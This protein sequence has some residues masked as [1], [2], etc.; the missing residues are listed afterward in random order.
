ML[1]LCLFA[2]M[3]SLPANAQ[4]R[5]KVKRAADEKVYLDHADELRYDEFLRR[6]V[7]IVKGK[8]RFRYDGTVLTCDSAYFNQE[9]NSFEAF[10]HVNIVN[11]SRASSMRCEHARYNGNAQLIE[12]RKGVVLHY[13]GRTLY[14]DS[15]N[16][17]RLTESGNYWDGGRIVMRGMQITS[18]RGEYFNQENKANAY[19]NVVV[20]SPKYIIHTNTLYYDTK[21][22]E[23][24]VVGPST[25]KTQGN[26]IKT[27]E[28]YYYPASDRMRL[29][30]P[31]TI[32]SKER[33]IVGDNLQ[34]NSK[35]GESEGTGHVKVFDKVN[36]RHISGDYLR[37]NSNKRTGRGEGHVHYIDRKN[38]NSLTA[39]Y[40]DY[41]DEKA[42]AYG[43]ALAK[44]FSQKD[45]LFV[46][47]DTLRMF[48]FNLNTDS[49]YRK[50]Y[51][52]HNVRAYRTDVQGVCGHFVYN[53][54]D[55]C[56]RMYNDPI[57]W[58][59]N[60]QILGDSI[61]TYLNDT[62]IRESH[63]MGNALSIELMPDSIHYNQISS[64]EMRSYFVDGKPR[65]SEAIGQVLMVYYPESDKDSSLIGL[66]YAESDTMRMFLTRERKLQRIWMPKTQGTL[67]PMTQ[68]PADK[69]YLRNFKW[70]DYIRPRSK[71]DVFRVVRKGEEDSKPLL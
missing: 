28:G 46:H 70:Y 14:T 58:N 32:T 26:T 29:I 23:A 24:H 4:R 36:N 67:Y 10:G 27:N 65:W 49:V 37:Y 21:T 34:Y 15:L 50:V 44:D 31:S 13:A 20:R 43:H 16:Y 30:G 35:T 56:M 2:L 11:R 38:R 64:K 17:N 48:A 12:A 54:A 19:D 42:I 8:V 71:R 25:I 5:K 57:A 41:T 47:A 18:K 53:S 62:T 40:V 45:T 59:A 52:I 66:L 33:D 22:E 39:D 7:Q 1:A 3:L 60:R 9:Q 6:G 51:G 68:I 61:L 63:V 55:S 69:R